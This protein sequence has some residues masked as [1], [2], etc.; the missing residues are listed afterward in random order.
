MKKIKIKYFR[1]FFAAL[2]VLLFIFRFVFGSCHIVL[3]VSA[4][5]AIIAWQ[6]LSDFAE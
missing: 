3:C 5:A 1:W 2:F 6:I 4:L